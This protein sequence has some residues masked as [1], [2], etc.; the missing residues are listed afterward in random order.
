[1]PE[2]TSDID[3]VI[4]ANATDS[5]I[6]FVNKKKMNIYGNA[7]IQ[8]K[9]T[10]LKSENIFVDFNTSFI[11]AEGIPSDSVEGKLTGTPVLKEGPETYEGLRMKYNFKKIG[12]A[13]CREVV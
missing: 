1:I 2:T 6:F 10:D 8:Y 5:L 4:Y 12:R 3:T 11:E 7:S 13:S 9:Q